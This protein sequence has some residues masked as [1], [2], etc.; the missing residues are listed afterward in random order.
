RFFETVSLLEA[1]EAMAE[2]RVWKGL[3]DQVRV[4]VQSPLV[5]TIPRGRK[6]DIQSELELQEDLV[7]PLAAGDALGTVRL[8]LEGEVLHEGPVVALEAVEPAGFFAR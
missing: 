5:L 3:A 8:M 7:A 6:D 4:G 1:D 2:P